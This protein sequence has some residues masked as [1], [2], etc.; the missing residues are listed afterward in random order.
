MPAGIAGASIL[1]DLLLQATAQAIF[2]AMGFLLLAQAT[3]AEE[4]V[5]WGLAGLGGAAVA[6]LGFFLVLRL[7]GVHFVESTIAKLLARLALRSHVAEIIGVDSGLKAIW[8]NPT[9]LVMGFCMHFI[10]WLAGVVE[11]WVALTAMGH[12]AGLVPAAII[13]SLGQALRGAAFPVPG[14]L[15]VQEGGFVLLCRLLGIDPA[16]AIA[17]SLIKRV[18]DV[19]LGLPG[20]LI[21]YGLEARR[22]NN[23]QFFRSWGKSH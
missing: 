18:P 17:L 1:V 3:G 7:G 2:A 16:T 20:L 14:A 10:A 6:L 13:E 9:N 11:I 5:K 19:A 12:P 22:G 8:A 4:V 15:G 23:G 21:W